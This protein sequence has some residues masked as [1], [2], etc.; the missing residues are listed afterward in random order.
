MTEQAV[1]LDGQMSSEGDIRTGDAAVGGAKLGIDTTGDGGL[2]TLHA[3]DRSTA[4]AL[5]GMARAMYPHDRLPDVHYERVIAALDQ[6]A[7]A[8]ERM[9]TLLT[10]GVG[11]LAT[12][13]GRH[14][15]EFASLPEDEQVAALTR[16][17]ETA[18]FTAVA[19]E[20]V[21]NLY[22]QPDVWPYFGYEGPSTEKGGYLHRGFD[23]INWLD[24]APDRRDSPVVERVATE[25]RISREG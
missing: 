3:L 20:I 22:S 21:V 19:A 10:E 17:Q 9:T 15:S 5:V 24:A 11:S 8:D 7:A 12:T 23:D 13:T 1:G 16:L 14:P 2:G 25:E 6:K 4:T 18:F